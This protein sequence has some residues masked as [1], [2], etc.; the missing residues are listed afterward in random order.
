MMGFYASAWWTLGTEEGKLIWV[1]LM[2][3]CESVKNCREKENSEWQMADFFF[4]C[5]SSMLNNYKENCFSRQSYRYNQ[6]YLLWEAFRNRWSR[7]LHRL[8]DVDLMDSTFATTN[9]A[10]FPLKI[11]QST[12]REN[13]QRGYVLVEL[14]EYGRSLSRHGKEHGRMRTTDRTHSRWYVRLRRRGKCCCSS[15]S[16]NS[17][18]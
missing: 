2:C 18:M 3:Q 6:L 11:E 13:H 16:V 14:I 7:F 10:G 1:V 9:A 17:R 5:R 4:S 15:V 12:C 8:S